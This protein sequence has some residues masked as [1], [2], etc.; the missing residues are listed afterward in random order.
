MPRGGK[1]HGAGR[2]P[3]SRSRE[4]TERL[5]GV[6]SLSELA[7]SYADTALDTL[8]A[9]TSDDTAPA[10]ARIAAACALLD[11]GYGRPPQRVELDDPPPKEAAED[12]PRLICPGDPEHQPPPE[13][14][15]EISHDLGAD[16]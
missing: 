10:S 7:R 6:R 12:V 5:A 16:E 11:R 15:Q 14:T 3:G 4:T 2:K 8:A 13:D 9:V 1:R